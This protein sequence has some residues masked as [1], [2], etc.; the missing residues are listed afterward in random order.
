MDIPFT[1]R[2]QAIKYNI[3]YYRRM[4]KLSQEKLAEKID[5]SRTHL[6]NIEAPNSN[7]GVHLDILYRIAYA[8]DIEIIKLLDISKYSELH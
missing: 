1:E 5:I 2:L 3:V 4:R 8:L 7:T 6:A